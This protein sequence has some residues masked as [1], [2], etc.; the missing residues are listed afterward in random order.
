MIPIS[1]PHWFLPDA[2]AIVRRAC[3]LAVLAG[4]IGGVSYLAM[5]VT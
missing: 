3:F 2:P 5:F 1:I 4:A